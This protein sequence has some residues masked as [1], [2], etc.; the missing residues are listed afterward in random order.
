M[1]SWFDDGI[2]AGWLLWTFD[3]WW[4]GT[5]KRARDT[6][7]FPRQPSP[8]TASD[9][10]QVVEGKFPVRWS[11][12]CMVCSLQ[13]LFSCS[14]LDFF[15]LSF[16]S[17]LSSLS[18]YVD[19]FGCFCLSFLKPVFFGDLF[20]AFYVE[21]FLFFLISF[22]TPVSRSLFWASWLRRGAVNSNRLDESLGH[23]SPI[24]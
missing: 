15:F 8:K 4:M 20:F 7:N 9:G 2:E 16:F 14:E 5:L 1:S 10:G 23:H 17:L 22:D 19:A 11:L 21:Y 13:S 6:P 12:L 24:H 3:W 18:L